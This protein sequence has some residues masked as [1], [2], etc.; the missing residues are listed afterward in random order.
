MQSVLPEAKATLAIR[1]IDVHGFP[2]MCKYTMKQSMDRYHQE[3]A[4]MTR[5]AGRS[6]CSSDTLLPRNALKPLPYFSWCFF[7]SQKRQASNLK[8]VM[9]SFSVFFEKLSMKYC[10]CIVGR[11]SILL[12]QHS[13]NCSCKHYDRKSALC[14]HWMCSLQP[15]SSVET[16]PKCVKRSKARSHLE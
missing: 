9:F 1:I 5:H 14:C 8:L 10:C 3:A 16:A 12:W 2:A 11:G 6:T 7:S 4:F 15:Y 13:F